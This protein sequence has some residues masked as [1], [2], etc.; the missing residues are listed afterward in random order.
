MARTQRV[1]ISIAALLSFGTGACGGSNDVAEPPRN[2][3]PAEPLFTEPKQ[4]L[5]PTTEAPPTVAPTTIAFVEP[6]TTTTT[7]TPIPA[8]TLPTVESF[9]GFTAE[10]ISAAMTA[11]LAAQNEYSRQL[12]GAPI[13]LARLGVFMSK[14]YAQDNAE[15][16]QE[17][18]DG[19]RRFEAGSIDELQALSAE[20]SRRR[21]DV[22]I[23]LLCDKNNTAEL[24]T[25][26][27][28][29]TDDDVLIQN[30]LSTVL[31][32]SYMEKVGDSWKQIGSESTKDNRCDA[33]FS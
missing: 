30:R 15:L 13:D 10:D 18:R 1:V 12:Q 31:L 26:G 17:I 7:T 20:P 25:K 32:R 22:L 4:A 14:Q 23:V 16:L 24:D 5:A 6:T 21:T 8:T 9:A 2:T 11:A 29:N 19:G 27:T 28:A 3:V 33:L